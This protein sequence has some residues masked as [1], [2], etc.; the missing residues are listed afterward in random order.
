MKAINQCIT[1]LRSL[2]LATDDLQAIDETL[3]KAILSSFD[4]KTKS[5]AF[6]NP[7]SNIT[8]CKEMVITLSQSLERRICY[9]SKDAFYIMARANRF[10]V[11]VRYRVFHILFIIYDP[12]GAVSDP[13][14]KV[15]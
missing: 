3:G 1:I 8:Y 11:P 4:L 10:T 15:S 13:R 5:S 2:H 12:L 9:L 7:K 14:L 6:A